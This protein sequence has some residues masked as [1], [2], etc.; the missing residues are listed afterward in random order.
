M[1]KLGSQEAEAVEKGSGSMGVVTEESSRAETWLI[2]QEER[3][4]DKS[5]QGWPG[6]G[7]SWLIIPGLG[8]RAS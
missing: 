5:L 8:V 1:R 4:E 2:S 3:V 7:D 6:V